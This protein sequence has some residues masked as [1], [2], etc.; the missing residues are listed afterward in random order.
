MKKIL[1][2]LFSILI[3]FNSYGEWT[4]TYSSVIGTT[5]YID[6][7]TIKKH[8]G[9][10]YWWDLSDYLIPTKSGHLSIKMYKQGDCG[11]NR[12]KILS[13]IFYRQPM[14]EG[15]NVTDALSKPEWVYPPPGSIA[16]DLLNYAC[17]PS[18]AQSDLPPTLRLSR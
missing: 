4:K 13:F 7:D 12:Y 16:S 18:I 9:Y 11:V 2:L 14:G 3:S 10:V 6:K 1:I 17:N 8:G 15:E 5:F